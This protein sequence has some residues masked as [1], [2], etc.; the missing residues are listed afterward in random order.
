[1]DDF[2]DIKDVAGRLHDIA[3]DLADMGVDISE[4]IS[5]EMVISRLR[6][7]VILWRRWTSYCLP[8]RPAIRYTIALSP[9][10]IG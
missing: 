1:M 5:D 4:A 2:K 3:M 8:Y 10:L 6:I 7:S 9:I